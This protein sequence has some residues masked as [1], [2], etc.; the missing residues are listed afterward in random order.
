MDFTLGHLN[1]LESAKSKID[2]YLCEIGSRWKVVSPNYCINCINIIKPDEYSCTKCG[3]IFFADKKRVDYLQT[4]NKYAEPKFDNVNLKWTP[5][6]S[7]GYLGSLAPAIGESQ[8]EYRERLKWEFAENNYHKI[9]IIGAIDRKRKDEERKRQAEERR[10]REEE[11]IRQF[12]GGYCSS[13]CRYHYEEII[14]PQGVSVD[15]TDDMYGV[16]YCCSLGHSVSYGSFCK[17]YE[18]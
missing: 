8:F 17:D 2:E 15:Y 16:D 11:Y 14:T 13:S 7:N 6:F 12:G 9:G 4:E 1:G 5:K 10:R 3:S 18:Q